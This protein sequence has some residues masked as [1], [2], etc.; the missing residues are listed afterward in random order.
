[1][2]KTNSGVDLYGLSVQNA[3]DLATAF[4]SMLMTDTEMVNFVNV[5]GPKLAALVPRPKL[6]VGEHN[7]WYKLP[8]F[9]AAIEASPP[10]LAATDIY[11]THQYLDTCAYAP[12]PRPIWQSQV[13]TGTSYDAGLASGVATASSV[14]YALTT[15][16]A[17]AWHYYRLYNPFS[18]DNSGLI[19]HAA[20][21]YAVTKRLYTLG[22]YSKF[23]RPGWVRIEASGLPGLATAYKN[24]ATG[25]FA[26][27]VINPGANNVSFS[28]N[29]VGFAGAASVTPWETSAANDLQALA[30]IPIT[31]NKLL[32]TVAPGVTTFVGV[33]ESVFANGFE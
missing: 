15:G 17:T 30:P 20:A 13:S 24:P 29:L 4:A 10:A 8:N 18:E 3:P 25:E 2:L 16:N 5:L 23:I 7:D 26:I 14:H 27:V 9:A 31:A 6:I 12:R 33:S 28:A 21:H 1:L 22:N 32:A 19:G 11:G